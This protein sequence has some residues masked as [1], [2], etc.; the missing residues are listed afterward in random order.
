MEGWHLVCLTEILV[1]IEKNMAT[2]FLATD[3]C[4]SEAT[5]DLKAP[6]V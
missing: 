3:I 2:T 4:F 1:E 6:L 5:V